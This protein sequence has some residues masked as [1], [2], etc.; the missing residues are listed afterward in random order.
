MSQ[1]LINSG[2]SNLQQGPNAPNVGIK[3]II[4]LPSNLFYGTG[5]PACIIVIDKQDAHT[6]NGIFMIDA[7]GG[8]MKDGPKNRL[9]SQDI[10]KIVDAFTKRLEIPRYSRMVTVQEIEEGEFSLNLPRYIDSQVPADLQDIEGHLKGGIPVADVEALAPYWRVCPNLKWALFKPNRPKYFDGA[11]EKTSIKPTIY[12][13]PEFCAFTKDMNVHFSI[14]KE[15]AAK[16]LKALGPGCHPKMIIAQLSEDLLVHYAGKPLIDPYDIYQHVMDYWAETMQDDCYVIAA[17]GWKAET[18]RVI[19]TDK[20]GKQ[21]DKGW[22]CDLVPKSLIVARYFAKE[23]ASIG[24]QT[25]RLE[26]VSAKLAEL[27]EENSGEE[28]AFSD[29][30]RV[31]RATVSTRLK[32]IED[33]EESKEEVAVLQ[34]WLKLNAEESELKKRRKDAETDLDAKSYAQYSKLGESEI[35]ALVV[36]NK[37]L[38]QMDRALQSVIEGVSLLL[39]Q[40]V[41]E[42]TERYQTPMPEMLSDIGALESKVNEHLNRLGFTW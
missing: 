34:S 42:L 4:G 20:K 9:R 27:E 17:D 37:W 16:Y 11:V 1:R 30:E 40:R 36:D 13:H 5:I 21:K 19:E 33:D 41:W 2:F 10:H 12:G 7:S 24:E 28:D 3:G 25:G 26:S 39:A 15:K 35:K 32:E 8:F 29:L 23:Q 31:N 22:A 6:R 14:W 38:D 18:Y